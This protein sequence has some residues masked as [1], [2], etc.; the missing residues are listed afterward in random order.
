[1]T[2]T[3]AFEGHSL[4]TTQIVQMGSLFVLLLAA[5]LVLVL[6]RHG[7][8]ALAVTLALCTLVLPAVYI[9]AKQT[10]A[11]LRKRETEDRLVGQTREFLRSN[12]R[13]WQQSAANFVRVSEAEANAERMLASLPGGGRELPTQP[14][15]RYG[16]I[17]SVLPVGE[18]VVF[19]ALP[20]RYAIRGIY[21]RRFADLASTMP[22]PACMPLNELL[23]PAAAT[24]FSR[25]NA[26][27]LDFTIDYS[28]AVMEEI[29][30]RAAE[31]YQRLRHGGVEVG[32]VLFG[33]HRESGIRVQALRAISCD[34]ANGPRFVLSQL[35]ELALDDLLRASVSDP[36]LAG[37]EPLG[38]F[39]SH[40][41][42]EICLSQADVQLFDR[43]FP[44]SWQVALVVRPANLAP[45][46]AGFFYREA[47]GSMRTSSSYCEFQLA[48]S[49][50]SI[51]V[52]A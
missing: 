47:E 40:T 31:G 6:R 36:E 3:D 38:W 4:K 8:L 14:F 25:W 49:S 45:T 43:F 5:S 20:R 7:G 12:E 29:R 9:L 33:T 22:A 16:N 39:H 50:A 44:Q 34:Y 30:M 35:D 18:P 27:P 10:I 41:R 11:S 1:M 15:Q 26:G 24:G 51:E 13:E 21:E 23:P 46:R 48:S 37:L 32:G 52:A 19:D 17:A 42:E 28:N 2:P